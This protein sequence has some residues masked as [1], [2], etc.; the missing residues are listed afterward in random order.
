M[1]DVL[2]PLLCPLCRAVH[3]FDKPAK[4]GEVRTCP[5]IDRRPIT[6]AVPLVRLK[7]QEGYEITRIAADRIEEP[8][9]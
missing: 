1:S 5:C 4:P 2:F 9:A 7:L 6:T 8:Q 3:V